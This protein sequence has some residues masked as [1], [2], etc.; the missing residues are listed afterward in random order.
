MNQ[1]ATHSITAIQMQ[2]FN[3][4][5]H[6]LNRLGLNLL[7]F[8]RQNTC[9]LRMQ[10]GEFDSDEAQLSQPLAQNAS[11][12]CPPYWI[13]ERFLIYPVSEGRQ[14][15]AL[16][17]VDRGTK[18]A[19]PTPD[20]KAYL[21]YILE[22]WLRQCDSDE[23]ISAQLENI[24]NELSQAYEE[25]IMLYNLSSNMKVTQSNS[26]YLQMACDQLTR[27]IQVEGIA[28]FLERRMDNHKELVLTA[29]SGF[30]T[31]DTAA[32]DILQMHL[33]AELGRGQEALLDSQVDGPFNYTWPEGVRNLIAVP[34][35]D[36]D[37]MIGFLMATNVQ[38]KLDF[39]TTDIKLF[40]S[41]ANQCRVFIENNHLFDDL[42]ELFIGSLKA[43]TNSIDAKDQY[44]RGHSERV[45]FISRWIAEHMARTR[46]L[47]QKQVHYIYLAGLLH[48]IGK[49][50]VSEAVL[51]KRGRLTDEERAVIQAHPRI[52]ASILAEIR[53]MTD[54]VPGVLGHHE[55]VD[56]SGYPQGLKGSSIPL[57]ARIIALADAF[58]AMTSKRVYR[59]AMNIQEAINQIEEGIGTQ[60]DE[61]VAHAFL[62]SD[63]EK[64]WQII[65]DGF[66]E[67][68]DYSNFE[69]YG[70]S[71]V[72]ALIR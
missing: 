49:I 66:I 18:T 52:G 23:Q 62:D 4:L 43:L 71:A 46:P 70:V 25:I 41:V 58:D 21:L 12:D 5:G 3:Q 51:K 69:E 45:A 26:T 37:H 65:Q 54:I 40:N 7:V 8:D 64:L 53:Q 67:R 19:A 13:D 22:E 50:G 68:W 59:D 60:F 30:L 1:T 9:I 27:L 14:P 33:M 16:A 2:Q 56:G 61:D 11:A 31:V 57:I 15:Y 20:E 10:A 38:N 24:S 72:G 29:G 17:V 44:T 48:D 6:R 55:R 32:A 39:D 47:S 35:G 28:I 34:L 42:K 36:A 63:I